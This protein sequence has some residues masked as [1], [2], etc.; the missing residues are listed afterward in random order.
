MRR[1]AIDAVG[2][3]GYLE[4]APRLLTV[5]H[6]ARGAARGAREALAALGDR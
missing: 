4:L 1:V 2:E 6:L 3:G 5:P